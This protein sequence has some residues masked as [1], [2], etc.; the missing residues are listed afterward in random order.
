[1]K[2]PVSVAHLRIPGSLAYVHVPKPSRSDKLEPRAWKGVMV[3]YAMGTRGFRIWDPISGG[4]FESKHVKFDEARLYKDVIKTHVGDSPF[5]TEFDESSF[6]PSPNESSDSEDEAPPPIAPRPARTR[7]VPPP[8]A[9]PQET[10]LPPA[11][12][13]FAT[14]DI[15]PFVSTRK[16]DFSVATTPLRPTRVAHRAPVPHKPGWE[17]E[18]V[19]RQ[20]GATKGQW[21]VYYYAPSLRTALRS[22]PDIKA[23]CEVHLK[24]KYRASDYDFNPAHAADSDNDD[25]P[26]QPRTEQTETEL[27]PAVDDESTETYAVRVYC[28][29]VQEPST[30]EEAMSSPEYF[31]I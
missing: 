29:S 28:A 30:F 5:Q 22:R 1:M 7:T 12:Q 17:R 23:W 6:K 15:P 27:E 11:A 9:Q 24:E 18:E 13:K 14:Q 25:D 21:D 19:R 31:L 26:E 2:R 3:G 8:V 16:K 4:V 20:S 10:S